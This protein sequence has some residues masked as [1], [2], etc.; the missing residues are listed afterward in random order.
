MQRKSATVELK[1]ISL[2]RGG[3]SLF[4][5]LSLSLKAGEIILLT[6]ANGCGKSSLMRALAGFIPLSSGVLLLDGADVALDAD[7]LEKFQDHL[8]YLG[9]QNGLKPSLSLR[10]NLSLSATIALG[11]TVTDAEIYTAADTLDV[12][13]LLDEPV[14]Y[15]SSGQQ[16]RGAL[17]GLV[18][19]DKG[20]WLM[21]EPTV[22]L[23][24]E[25]R[26]R[27]AAVMQDHLNA[28]GSIIAAT[29][30]DLGLNNTVASTPITLTD[31]APQG[32]DT[33]LLDAELEGWL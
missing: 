8:C 19:Q 14:K 5:G 7:A 31:Y 27:L 4:Q 23:D 21:D 16:R 28:G 1:N 26:A 30:E 9:H 32:D 10:K 13:D 6:G 20:L 12:A 33:E 18:L 22:G 25:N 17:A 3:R 15:F 24:K 29:H 2:T 11:R